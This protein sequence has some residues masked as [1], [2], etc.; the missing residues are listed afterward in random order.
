LAALVQ[1]DEYAAQVAKRLWPARDRRLP[2]S[3]PFAAGVGGGSVVLT[4]QRIG[5]A[6]AD[7]AV[8]V[9]E[10]EQGGADVVRRGQREL[11]FRLGRVHGSS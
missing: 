8:G 10:F 1:P 3:G 4:P 5:V 6:H 11:G 2:R 9:L 7:Q